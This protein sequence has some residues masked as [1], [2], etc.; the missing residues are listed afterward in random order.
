M[1]RASNLAVYLA[2][3]EAEKNVFKTIN[4]RSVEIYQ[5]ARQMKRANQDVIGREV[6]NMELGDEKKM[7]AGESGKAKSMGS[8]LSLYVL[9]KSGK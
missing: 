9:K 3:N 1:R 6:E 7:N 4:P 8:G 2:R 5:M